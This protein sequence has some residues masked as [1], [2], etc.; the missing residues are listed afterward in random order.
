MNKTVELREMIKEMVDHE[1]ETSEEHIIYS[2]AE[3]FLYNWYEKQTEDHIKKLYANKVV[4]I[5]D[6]NYEDHKDKDEI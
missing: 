1:L 2:L 6:E 4:D 3:D 5:E